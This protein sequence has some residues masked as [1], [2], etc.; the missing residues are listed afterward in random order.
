MN[1]LAI[2]LKVALHRHAP[3]DDGL[4]RYR[5]KTTPQV[6]RHKWAS[7]YADGM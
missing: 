3:V 2:M 6:A 1:H 5:D 7:Q 4:Q